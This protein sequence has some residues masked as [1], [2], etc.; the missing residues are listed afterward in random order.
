[1]PRTETTL[2]VDR[3]AGWAE[4]EIEETYTLTMSTPNGVLYHDGADLWCNGKVS[5]HGPAPSEWDASKA[6]GCSYKR[7]FT[8]EVDYS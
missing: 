5:W 3:R 1:M 7:R 4:V 6:Q 8:L 2:Y